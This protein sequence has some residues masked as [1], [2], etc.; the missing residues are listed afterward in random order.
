MKKMLRFTYTSLAEK[1]VTCHDCEI[2][3]SCYRKQK[4][5]DTNMV[6]DS[7]IVKRIHNPKVTNP[8]WDFHQLLWQ[9]ALTKMNVDTIKNEY[10]K[11]WITPDLLK[12]ILDKK[13]SFVDCCIFS[14]ILKI[15]RNYLKENE[16]K[17]KRNGGSIDYLIKTVIVVRNN[18]V[19]SSSLDNNLNK[20]IKEF[21]KGTEY[22]FTTDEPVFGFNIEN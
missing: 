20:S 21:V 17:F 18:K 14:D 5:Y 22:K 10:L 19:I 8:E 16:K 6:C 9:I 7:I 13:P 11:D 3:K 2:S 1:E 12:G 15:F 4:G